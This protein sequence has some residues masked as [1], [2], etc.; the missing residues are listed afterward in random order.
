[1]KDIW[2]SPSDLS[3]FWSE[4]KVGFYDKYVLKIYRPKQAF[5]SVFNTIDLAMKDCFDNKS[6]LEFVENAPEGKIIH[7]DVSVQSKLIKVG[8]FKVGF[9]GKIDCLLDHGDGTYSVIDYK[10]T[11]ISKKLDEIYYLQLMAYAFS[12]ENP[13]AGTPK[14]ISNLGLIVFQ[15]E[16]FASE[17]SKGNLQGSL[18]YV[19]IKFDK[20]KFKKWISSELSPILH[21]E[22]E[23][24]IVSSSDKSW[25][26]YI[27]NF[28][29]IEED[30]SEPFSKNEL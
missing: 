22:R 8:D 16:S 20:S 13:L 4:S 14:K 15:P 1:M 7:E 12:L 30:D 17:L 26:R 28:H 24:I 21:T 18:H 25:Q 3:Y 10:T 6:I 23:K 9:K 29:V 27:N 2:I 11:H 19:N 5:P